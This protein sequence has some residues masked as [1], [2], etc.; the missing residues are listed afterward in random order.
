MET[1]DI[2]LSIYVSMFPYMILQM[3]G[4]TETSPTNISVN[5]SDGIC[6]I[7]QHWFQTWNSVDQMLANVGSQIYCFVQEYRQHV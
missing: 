6:F 4:K 2:H 3:D 5:S 7:L 1:I